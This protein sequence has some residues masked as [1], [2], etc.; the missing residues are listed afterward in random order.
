MI[1]RPII[2]SRGI[3]R[4]ANSSI[5]IIFDNPLGK[6]IDNFIFILIQRKWDK[7]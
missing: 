2:G 5:K 4:P 7:T 6:E 1:P 3:P